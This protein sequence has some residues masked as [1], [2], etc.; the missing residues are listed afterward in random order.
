MAV[1]YG[2]PER[3]RTHGESDAGLPGRY[4][5]GRL[6]AAVCGEQAVHGDQ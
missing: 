1:T 5:S 4:R 2:V 3:R 6:A